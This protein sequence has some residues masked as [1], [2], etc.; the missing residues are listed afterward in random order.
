LARFGAYSLYTPR[1]ASW[2]N[3]TII[4][5]INPATPKI[6]WSNLLAIC[7]IIQSTPETPQTVSHLNSN[8]TDT[9]DTFDT[10]GVYEIHVGQQPVGADYVLSKIK[11]DY[12]RSHFS[13]QAGF[14]I[15]SNF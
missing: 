12:R 3:I 9:P 2:L 1:H 7:S 13:A 15:G 11:L 4:V 8:F 14:I 6:K 5:K 10:P